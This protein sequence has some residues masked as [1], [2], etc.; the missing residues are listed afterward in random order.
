MAVNS[1]AYEILKF[2]GPPLNGTAY[3]TG[4]AELA[5]ALNAEDL[6]TV[7]SPDD[8]S[9]LQVFSTP[10]ASRWRIFELANLAGFRL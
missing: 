10:H 3:A 1:K 4:V 2:H 7:G 8:H 5:R 9:R 6:G